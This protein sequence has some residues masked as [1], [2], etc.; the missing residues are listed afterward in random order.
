MGRGAR[1]GLVRWARGRNNLTRSGGH[2]V[3]V[4]RHFWWLSPGSVLT[5]LQAGL[6]DALP[7]FLAKAPVGVARA[8]LLSWA[9]QVPADVADS[10]ADAIEEGETVGFGLAHD[11]VLSFRALITSALNIST[12]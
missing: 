10:P 5:A 11:A 3:H 6:L 7:S 2:R 1:D 12:R 9:I 8:I 4:K